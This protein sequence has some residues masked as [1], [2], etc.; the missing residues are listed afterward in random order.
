[1][2]FQHQSHRSTDT[3]AAHASR[4]LLRIKHLLSAIVFVRIKSRG[5]YIMRSTARGHRTARGRSIN[6]RLYGRV[7][8]IR[9][10]QESRYTVRRAD[11]ARVQTAGNPM[12][13]A[14]EA[15]VAML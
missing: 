8:C 14:A 1:M 12:R 2:Q 6:N 7:L 5:Q 3:S 15:E 10:N 4:M 9:C 13:W 11:P